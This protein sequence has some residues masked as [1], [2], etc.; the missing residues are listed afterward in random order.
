MDLSGFQMCHLSDD[1]HTILR[2][3]RLVLGLTQQQVANKAGIVLQQYQKF[4]S[5]DRN[6][7]TCSF[8][9]ACRVIEAL[10]MDIT[11]FYHGKYA[12]G[13]EVYSSDEGLRYKRT[14]KLTS[15]DID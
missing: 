7:M 5:G 6:I 1:G 14:G 11:D 2:E 10:E 3:K 15:E 12:F 13:E 9:I 8:R 4:E